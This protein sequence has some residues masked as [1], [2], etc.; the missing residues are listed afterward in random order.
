MIINATKKKALQTK[1]L[2]RYET[3]AR[4]LPW[5]RTTD[6]YK[7]LVS[8]IMSQQ[9]QVERVKTKYKARL[10]KFPT[11]EDL[12][13]ASQITILEMWSGLG[14]NRRGLNLWKA[15]IQISNKR[16]EIKDKKYFPHTE[17]DLLALTGVGY[18][19]AHAVMAFAYNAEVP[20]LDI[21]IK[22]VIIT[23]LGLDP[24]LSDKELREVAKTL[25]PAGKSRE[26]HNALMDYGALVLTSKKTGIRSAPQSQFVGSTR[27]VR[28]N[29]IKYL[30]KNKK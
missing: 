10:E 7:I 11:V 25:I 30:I 5:R 4:D 8:E 27:R 3:N 17:E 29:T 16:S 12:A 20:V 15:G 9:T 6:P 23:E 14:Y 2:S 26:R 28:G 21:N 13:Q 19:T 24:T 18:Y 22:R 1:I